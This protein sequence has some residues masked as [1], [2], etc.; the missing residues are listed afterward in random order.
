[1]A[2][3]AS[4]RRLFPFVH[5]KEGIAYLDSAASTQMPET[6]I[7]A[8]H[9]AARAGLGNPHRG[10]HPLG[11]EATALYDS[12]KKTVADFLN[13]T[14]DNIVFT[15]NTTEALNLAARSLGESW[16][17]GDVVA[18]TRLEH[19]S[20]ILPWQQLST[21][22]VEVRWIGITPDGLLDEKDVANALRDERV[23]LLAVT[24]QSNVLGVRPD[25]KM[26]VAKAK[27]IGA[28]TCVDAAQL[29]GHAH[30]D[31][32]DI[33]CDLLALSGHK[34][35][36]PTGIGA[37]YG[38]KEILSTMPPFLTGGGMVREVHD[39][40]FIPFE[41]AT[42]FEAGTP[43]LLPAIGWAAALQWQ[44]AIPWSDREAHERELVNLLLDELR[45]IDGVTILGPGDD[46]AYGC[47]SF[48]VDGAHPHDIGHLLGESGVCVRAGHHCAGPLHAALGV[49][50][51]VRASIGLYTD[52]ND[53]RA[54]APAI[55][56]AQSVLRR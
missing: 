22:G 38:T 35:Y 11:D 39:D 24:G 7:D 8:M 16:S 56:K 34:T 17:E 44:T 21:R 2:F 28:L 19:H 37:L 26:L 14:P 48:T 12:A 27:S 1:M 47:V 42:R 52:A 41:D 25:V 29:A 6:A 3:D 15:K 10:I 40:G 31:V 13:A 50:A 51:S 30:I 4:I 5:A 46:R 53:I 45:S 9:H 55:R 20:N 32:K 49:T 54:L 36:G 18:V 33:G 23:K 43:P